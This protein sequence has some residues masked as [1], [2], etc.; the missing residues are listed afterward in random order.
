MMFKIPLQDSYDE[1]IDPN[2]YAASFELTISLLLVT[3]Q[4]VSPS[5]PLRRSLCGGSRDSITF[6]ID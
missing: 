5:P 6:F 2:D 4:N 3:L 1:K